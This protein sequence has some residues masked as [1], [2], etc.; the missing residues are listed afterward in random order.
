MTLRRGYW[1]GSNLY[2]AFDSS[3]TTG[4]TDPDGA[5]PNPASLIG[6]VAGETTRLPLVRTGE[7]PPVQSLHFLNTVHTVDSIDGNCDRS[8]DARHVAG[9]R[10]PVGGL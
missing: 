10:R 4:M 7:P 3:S 6:R 1:D 5:D 9:L 2:Q 8:V